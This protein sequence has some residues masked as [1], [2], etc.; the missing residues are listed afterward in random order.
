M[1][2]IQVKLIEKIFTPA[3]KQEL[4]SKLTDVMVSMKGDAV[5]PVVWVTIEEVPSGAWGMGGK[6][7]TT[8]AVLALGAT[9]P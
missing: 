6:A 1:A 3:E 2:L 5:R 4:I 9:K 7:T 8:E